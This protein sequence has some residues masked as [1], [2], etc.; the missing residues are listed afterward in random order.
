GFNPK[1]APDSN[2]A[3]KQPVPVAVSQLKS[4]FA[5]SAVGFVTT[6]CARY[7][8]LCKYGTSHPPV[9]N[10]GVVARPIAAFT[11]GS[12][13]NNTKIER[14]ANGS[15]ALA[16]CAPLWCTAGIGFCISRTSHSSPIVS[17][18]TA[19]ALS[20]GVAILLLAAGN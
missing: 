2:A 3:R 9:L 12:P 15:Q 18:T 7:I 10:A 1:I 6:G 11:A 19:G 8:A 16:T 20:A 17:S 4:N 13:H 5:F 14:I